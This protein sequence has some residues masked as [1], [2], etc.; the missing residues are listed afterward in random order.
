MTLSTGQNWAITPKLSNSRKIGRIYT[1]TNIT[2]IIRLNSIILWDGNMSISIWDPKLRQRSR[3]FLKMPVFRPQDWTDY[4]GSGRW[5]TSDVPVQKFIAWMLE[6]CLCLLKCGAETLY[7]WQ[8][9]FFVCDF[10][11]FTGSMRPPINKVMLAWT[12]TLLNLS[13]Q[14]DQS[15]PGTGDF[16]FFFLGYVVIRR[17]RRHLLQFLF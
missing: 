9:L 15:I 4:L 12:E 11:Q 16:F 2:S 14:V 5:K 8:V 7:H 10:E 3:N 13:L 1:S 17:L 6:S